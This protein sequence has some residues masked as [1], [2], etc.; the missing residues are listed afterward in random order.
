MA[1]IRRRENS[2]GS[3]S[4]QVKIRLRGVR[5]SRTFRR[6]GDAQAWARRKEAQI[7]R[8]EAVGVP[9]G[10][11]L[12]DTVHAYLE[13]PS[14]A[15]LSPNDQ[16]TRRARLQ[17]WLD[18]FSGATLQELTSGAIENALSDLRR[19]RGPSG[20]ALS[21]TTA[22]G[23]LV[24]LSCALR[25][26]ERREWIAVN[27]ARRVERPRPARGRDRYLRRAEDSEGLE[28]DELVALLQSARDS[29]CRRLFPGVVISLASGC[30]Q[31][32][33]FVH[34]HGT[35]TRPARWE[36]VELRVD[37]PT[38]EDLGARI[39]VAVTKSL[40]PK[41]LVLLHDAAEVLREFAKVRPLRAKLLMEDRT[42]SAT[43]PKSAW[44]ECLRRAGIE[45]LRWHDLRH[46]AGSYLGMAGYSVFQIAQVLGCTPETAARYTHLSG[47]A[48]R[49][50]VAGGTSKVLRGA[51]R[52]MDR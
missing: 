17:W 23:Y 27:P 24:T 46:S 14:W 13:S 43:F 44:A 18:R 31:S 2:D 28:R 10:H 25:L 5:K 34:E 51:F 38:G 47:A 22:L 16:R 21:S 1:T 41:T 52:K 6:R 36:D 37:S 33:L 7:D 9:V 32:E 26:A 40:K 3:V 4:W 39:H 30:R 11:T 50:V 29:R 19:G 35:H 20:R 8:G 48:H 45:G 12:A 15:A 49:D 42:G